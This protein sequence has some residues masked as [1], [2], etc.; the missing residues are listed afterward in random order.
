M[1]SPNLLHRSLHRRSRHLMLVACTLFLSFMGTAVAEADEAEKP[2]PDKAGYNIFNPTPRNKMREF[3]PDRPTKT[4]GPFTVDAGHYQ[5]EMSF[6]EFTS[7]QSDAL[8]TETWNVA[9]F[10]FKIGLCNST[11]LEFLFANYLNVRTKDLAARTTSTQSGIGDLTLRLKVN[12]WGNDGGKTAFG[13]LPLLKLPTNTDHLGNSSVEGGVIFPLD[14]KLPGGWDMGL[15]SAPLFLRDV[16]GNGYHAEIV[17]SVALSHDITDKLGGYVEFFSNVS[18]ERGSE[19]VGTVDFGLTYNLLENLQ[20]DCGVNVGVTSS[21][22]DVNAF[23]GMTVR[24]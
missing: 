12:L 23:T 9:P 18:T 5:L 11:D 14:L 6:L 16:N 24:F 13:I 20:L 17:H 19:W 2:V 8:R 15:E 1:P 22:D 3:Y 7:H 10:T 21:A 4:E